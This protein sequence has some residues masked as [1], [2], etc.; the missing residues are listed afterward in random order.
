MRAHLFHLFPSFHM[1]SNRLYPLRSDFYGWHL[2]LGFYPSHH[3][4]C[5][6]RTLHLQQ[7]ISLYSAPIVIKKISSS[8][9]YP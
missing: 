4:L 3:I 2:G 7:G 5:V 6:H 1:V 8:L 9:Y